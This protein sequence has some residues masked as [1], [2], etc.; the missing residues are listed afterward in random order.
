VTGVDSFWSSTISKD[1]LS[2]TPIASNVLIAHPDASVGNPGSTK[3]VRVLNGPSG[4]TI[5]VFACGGVQEIDLVTKQY[6]SIGMLTEK[7]KYTITDAHVV[8]GNVLKSFVMDVQGNSYFVTFDLSVSGAVASTPLKV[9][10]IKGQLGTEIPFNAFVY[11]IPG[12]TKSQIMLMQRGNFDSFTFLDE[13]TG[14]LTAVVANLA[15]EQPYEIYCDAGTKDCDYWR[16]AMVDPATGDVY[17][18]LHVIENDMPS[19]TIARL[20]FFTSVI[21][22]NPYAIVNIVNEPMVSRSDFFFK[23]FSPDIVFYSKSLLCWLFLL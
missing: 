14:V 18:Q 7:N 21:D 9:V 23:L 5:A 1:V 16:T 19:A 8:D 3:L 4:R 10:P 15:Q 20:G 6:K 17:F 11:T 2:T 13:T 22:P 12:Q